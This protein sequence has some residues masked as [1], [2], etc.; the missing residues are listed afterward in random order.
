MIPIPPSA[1]EP[2]LPARTVTSSTKVSA[3]S[4]NIPERPSTLGITVFATM[5]QRVQNLKD[6]GYTEIMVNV[7]TGDICGK[8][9]KDEYKCINIYKVK[10]NEN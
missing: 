2:A 5:Q 9:F 8:N 7:R 6:A 1:L 3:P 4:I 10:I